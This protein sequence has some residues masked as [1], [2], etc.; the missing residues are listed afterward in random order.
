M[1]IIF[2]LVNVAVLPFWLL[3]ILAPCW[4]WTVRIMGSLVVPVLF[5][6]LYAVLVVPALPDVLPMLLR[7]DLARIGE[8]LG[9]PEG[10]VVG[11]IHFL[12]FDL[13]VGR[14]EYLDARQR[15]LSHWLLA[16]A[17]FL[18]LMFGP[19]GLLTYLLLRWLATW[20]GR[21]SLA[22]ENGR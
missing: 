21:A 7:P 6:G 8:L 11:W 13:F 20:A 17:L 2:Q 18:T 1:E 4:R 10:T 15:G 5:A 22:P 19:L 3:M 12:T 16:P 9:R 14:W